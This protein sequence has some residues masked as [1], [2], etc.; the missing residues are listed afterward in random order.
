VQEVADGWVGKETEC[1][2][3]ERLAMEVTCAGWNAWKVASSETTK[4]P[5][6]NLGNFCQRNF[7]LLVTWW[8]WPFDAQ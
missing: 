7:A 5:I 3:R 6:T 4:K 2:Q 8:A 1:A